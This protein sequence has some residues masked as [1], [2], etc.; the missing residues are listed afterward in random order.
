MIIE[1]TL[2]KGHNCARNVHEHRQS[3]LKGWKKQKT[4][5]RINTL[6]V[7]DTVSVWRQR[8]TPLLLT[9]NYRLSEAV[10]HPLSQVNPASAI[11][12]ES[13]Y[14][15]YHLSTGH[16]FSQGARLFKED[17]N[18]FGLTLNAASGRKEHPPLD[19]G[20]LK[21]QFGHCGDMFGSCYRARQFKVSL[22]S[23]LYY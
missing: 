15:E 17:D 22:K 19:V 12:V 23:S 8:K 2:K 16:V 5:N 21:K 4:R 11:V 13:R 10:K 6:P 20:M 9:I 18:V 1:R 14:T 7:V 3:S